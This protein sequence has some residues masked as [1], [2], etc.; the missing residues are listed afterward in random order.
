MNVTENYRKKVNNYLKENKDD[1]VVYKLRNNLTLNEDD[2][3]HLE[4][5]LWEDLGTKEDYEK[6]FGDEPLLKLVSRIVGL[7]PKAAQ[8]LFSEF[9]NDEDLT[10]QQMEFVKQIVSYIIR[11]GSLEKQVLNEVPFNK[12]GTIIRLFDG[13]VDKAKRIIKKIDEVNE[14]LTM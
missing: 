6:E 11:N 10:T 2:L 4:K 5:I 8:E 7:E 13:K 14:R 3:K 1:L 9:L 12:S